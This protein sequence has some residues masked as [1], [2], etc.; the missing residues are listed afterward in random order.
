MAAT[1][2]AAAARVGAI[3]GGVVPCAAPRRERC[4][5]DSAADSFA[6]SRVLVIA[7]KQRENAL[8][9]IQSKEKHSLEK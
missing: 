3:A 5:R 8:E 9:T 4:G 6:S 1:A 7:Q 2:A